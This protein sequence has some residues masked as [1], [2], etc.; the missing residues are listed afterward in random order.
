MNTTQIDS[1]LKRCRLTTYR[2]VFASD[3]LPRVTGVLIANVDP[4]NKPGSHWVA[5]YISADRQRGEFF[6][7]FGR[8]PDQRLTLFM[9][10]NCVNWI[11]NKRQL[12]SVVSKCCGHYCI[13][14]CINR[15]KLGIDLHRFLTRFTKDTG[16][17]DLIVRKAVRLVVANSY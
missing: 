9:K 5:I 1:I 2:G 16:F 17:N 8:A 11:Y 12:Q 13:L 3:Q 14:Y 10:C 4:I 6:D 7:S 15:A